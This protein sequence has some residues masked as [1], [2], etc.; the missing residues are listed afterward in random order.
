MARWAGNGRVGW[1]HPPNHPD[2]GGAHFTPSPVVGGA[3]ACMDQSLTTLAKGLTFDRPC[4]AWQ[5]FSNEWSVFIQLS[6]V[7]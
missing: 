1:A 4:S 6:P 7:Y 3:H 5:K 2:S